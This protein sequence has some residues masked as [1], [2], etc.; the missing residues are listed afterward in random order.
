MSFW[1]RLFG[2]ESSVVVPPPTPGQPAVVTAI[3]H[4]LL[5]TFYAHELDEAEGSF[6]TAITQGFRN[7]RQREL[8]LTLRVSELAD[9][10]AI[11][12]ELS[13]L[14][15]SIY[16]LARARKIV[17]AGGFTQFK[18]RGLFGRGPSGLLYGDARPIR[19]LPVPEDALA[20]ICVDDAEVRTAMD[21]GVYRVLAR[22]GERER[23]FP[24]PIW[25]ALDRPSV[26]SERDQESA[27]GKVPRIRM[28][29][30]SFVVEGNRLRVELSSR[31][32]GVG[33][34]ISA[35]VPGAP[36]V[37]LL[38]PAGSANALFVW[39]PGQTEPA[40][41][42]APGTNG[43]RKTGS[44]LMIV[45]GGQADQAR[46]FEDGYTLLFSTASWQEVSFALR[47]QR[48]LTLALA[49][50]TVLEFAWAGAPSVPTKRVLRSH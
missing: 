7:Q 14:F 45:P 24:F 2:E 6:L 11:M 4:K 46:P 19:G 33:R 13:A 18:A 48:A 28:P 44:C 10:A 29:G 25:N 36:F 22:I 16:R 5:I 32:R 39:H 12:K 20:I 9:A 37:L 42:I 47:D 23:C 31:A 30:V 26:A 49:D 21:Y 38:E 35:L 8:V 27:L 41:V 15:V 1:S 43:A 40:G 17:H 3:R 34:G 50:G